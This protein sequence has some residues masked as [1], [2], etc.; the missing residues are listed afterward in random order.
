VALMSKP[1][2]SEARHNIGISLS[3]CT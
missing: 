1:G 2:R 3:C